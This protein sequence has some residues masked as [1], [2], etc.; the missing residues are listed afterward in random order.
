MLI[1]GAAIVYSYLYKI[2]I[3]IMIELLLNHGNV[4]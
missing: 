4:S 1:M 3:L 2:Q